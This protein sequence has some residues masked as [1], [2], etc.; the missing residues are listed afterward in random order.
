MEESMRQLSINVKRN[1]KTME[2]NLLG[3]DAMIR[4]A[5]KRIEDLKF[6]IEVFEK[7]KAAGEPWGGTQADS[8]SQSQQHS[9]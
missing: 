4:D 8:R 7:R 5:K 3:W 6:S 2:D 9:V 1:R